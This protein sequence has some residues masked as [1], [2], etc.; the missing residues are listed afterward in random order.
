MA[1]DLTEEGGR[2]TAL[3]CVFVKNLLFPLE[4]CVIMS[5][6]TV[7]SQSSLDS[8]RGNRKELWINPNS[9][10]FKGFLFLWFFQYLLT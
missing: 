4:N 6:E 2:H 8:R 1:A 3:F 5:Q 9:E 10:Y 7:R